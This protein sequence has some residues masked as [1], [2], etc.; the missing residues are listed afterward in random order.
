MARVRQRVGH[1]ILCEPEFNRKK[2]GSPA[3]ITADAKKWGKGGQV[4]P[5]EGELTTSPVR[6]KNARSTVAV[7]S[8]LHLRLLPKLCATATIYDCSRKERGVFASS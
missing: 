4:L 3:P 7:T 8:P 2:L 6:V 5:R 1:S